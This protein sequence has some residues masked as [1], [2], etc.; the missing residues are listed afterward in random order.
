MVVISS[1]VLSFSTFFYKYQTI[2]IFF[3]LISILVYAFYIFFD[4]KQIV[5][6]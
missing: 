4:T 1:L 6:G 3:A 5:G 2:E